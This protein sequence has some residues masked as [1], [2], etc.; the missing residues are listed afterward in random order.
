M[1]YGLRHLLQDYESQRVS[2][3]SRACIEFMLAVLIGFLEPMAPVWIRHCLGSKANSDLMKLFLPGEKLLNL[4]Q[5]AL[6]I[7]L[8]V[9]TASCVTSTS[10]LG[11]C[12]ST[13]PAILETP[14]HIGTLQRDLINV[15]TPQRLPASY[16]IRLTLSQKAIN[17][18]Q[19]WTDS[20]HLNNGGD[21]I[22]PP[23]DTMFFCSAS[24]IGWGAHLDSIL[25]GGKWLKKEASSQSDQFFWK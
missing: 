22:P 3:S 10:F 19:W 9:P 15:I 13:M 2:V 14:L 8:Q 25:I 1:F 24:K 11:L 12:Q 21:M 23:V 5:F 18:L 4:N 17:I 6:G 20:V 7:M 16:K